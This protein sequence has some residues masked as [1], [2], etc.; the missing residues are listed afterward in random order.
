MNVAILHLSSRFFDN[1]FLKHCN[2]S[3]LYSA[4]HSFV[5]PP[6]A[7]Q[8]AHLRSSNKESAVLIVELAELSL[9]SLPFTWKKENE[10]EELKS[11]PGETKQIALPQ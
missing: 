1:F 4:A 9:Q 10:D 5:S 3:P 7:F 6:A 2:I 11:C 8:A